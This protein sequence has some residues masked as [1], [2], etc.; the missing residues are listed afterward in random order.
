MSTFSGKSDKEISQLLDE[1]GIKHGPI[2]ESTRK[3]YEKKLK[4]AMAKNT[5][6]TSSDRTYYREEQDEVEYVTYHQP[7]QMIRHDG[8]GDVTRRTKVIDSDF[9]H[10]IRRSKFTDYRDDDDVDHINESVIS[11]T[12][13]TY[14]SY[15]RPGLSASKSIQRGASPETSK[16]GGVPVWLRVLVFLIVAVFL[17]YVYTCMEPA[18]EAPIKTIQ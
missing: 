8:F 5:K 1:Y 17:Y 12:Q 13:T 7:P 10:D 11:P 2:V 4:E 15:T 6:P 16:L 3:L 14:Q 18:E 9:A